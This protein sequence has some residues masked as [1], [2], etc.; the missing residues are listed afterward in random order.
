MGFIARAL[1]AHD[2]IPTLLF[3]GQD[4][5]LTPAEFGLDDYRRIDICCEEGPILHSHVRAVTQT[6]LPRLRDAPDLLMVESDSSSALGATLVGFVAGLPVA[7]LEAGTRAH[8]PQLFGPED[9]DRVAIDADADLLFAPTKT[10]GDNC[11]WKRCRK[12]STL[13][14]TSLAT[15]TPAI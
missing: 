3:T 9:E 10:E 5:R 15:D 1:L 2:V 13:L 6:L 4:S 12:E 8:E 14:A 11:F 7:H